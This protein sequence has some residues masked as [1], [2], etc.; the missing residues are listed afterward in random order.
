MR[1]Y[2]MS[3]REVRD[4]PVRTFWKLDQM[5]GR[6]RAEEILD[7]L[8]AHASAMGGDGVKRLIADLK[9]RV[10]RPVVVEQRGIA[11]GDKRRLGELFG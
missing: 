6:I 9:Q 5:I 8:P 1:F 7:W 10:G 11:E 4:M 3:F 2:G